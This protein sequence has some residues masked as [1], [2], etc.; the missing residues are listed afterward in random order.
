MCLWVCQQDVLPEILKQESIEKY[1]K[2][3][4]TLSGHLTKAIREDAWGRGEEEEGQ[5]Y[6][7]VRTLTF[8]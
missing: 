1:F 5:D 4:D 7:M 2:L 6:R 8:Q 3:I